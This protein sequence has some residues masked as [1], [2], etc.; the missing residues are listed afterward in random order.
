MADEQ[1]KTLEALKMAVQMEIDGK[2][3]YL[4]A[5]S[6]S[7]NELGRGLLNRLAAEE[8]YHR[9]KF[10]QI[11]NSIRE[12]KSW[13]I[14]DFQPDSGQKLRTVFARATASMDPKVNTAATELEAVQNA[15]AMENKTRDFYVEQAEIATIKEQKNF[16]ELVAGEEREHYMVL[17]DYY[18][19][20]KDPSGWFV[21]K[22]H[23]SLDGG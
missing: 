9:N 5:S 16:F 11:Y 7:S 15:M 21:R 22:E 1:E 19:F 12:K 8:D 18:D 13:P 3:Y 10:E 2:E 20:L 17:M 14:V 23:P 6:Q 4:K